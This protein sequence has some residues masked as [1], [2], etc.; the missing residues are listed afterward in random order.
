MGVLPAQTWVWVWVVEVV[1]REVRVVVVEF[2]VIVVIVVV[3]MVGTVP[4]TCT[5]VAV[6]A[7]GVAVVVVLVA[8]L[9]GLA[10][11]EAVDEGLDV[12]VSLVD[13]VVESADGVDDA[14]AAVEAVGGGGCEA[15]GVGA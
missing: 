1:G 8:V 4:T 6:V 15:G 11:V 9:P 13:V 2:V 7:V 14:I 12:T 10:V 5:A 3:V